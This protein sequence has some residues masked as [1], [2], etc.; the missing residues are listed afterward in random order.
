MKSLLS[1]KSEHS[2]PLMNRVHKTENS[3]KSKKN[4]LLC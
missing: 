2:S 4:I 1:K 3:E